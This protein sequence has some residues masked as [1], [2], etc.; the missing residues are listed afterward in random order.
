MYCYLAP[1]SS[2]LNDITEIIPAIIVRK[3]Q[4]TVVTSLK[5][6]T[7]QRIKVQIENRIHIATRIADF[8]FLFLSRG[9]VTFSAVNLGH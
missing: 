3:E 8:N 5:H 2:R 1:K 4:R 6:G 9:I 7:M